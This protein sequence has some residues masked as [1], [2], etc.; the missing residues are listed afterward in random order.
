MLAIHLASNQALL[1]SLVAIQRF[2][3]SSHQNPNDF[4]QASPVI[5]YNPF[6]V[7][8]FVLISL[9]AMQNFALD[10]ARRNLRALECWRAAAAADGGGGGRGAVARHRVT[11][12]R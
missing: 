7:V 11:T 5:L 9:L 1:L 10:W 8:R 4:D 3:S 6:Q 2:H 12:R